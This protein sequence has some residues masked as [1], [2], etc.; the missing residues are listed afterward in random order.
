MYHLTKCQKT[1]NEY[2]N[3]ILE[4]LEKLEQDTPEHIPSF[5]A[6]GRMD[7]EE[8]ANEVQAGVMF[9]AWRCLYA[10]LMSVREEGTLPNLKGAYKRCIRMIISRLTAYGAKWKRWCKINAGTGKKKIIPERF[11]DRT[12]LKQQKHGNYEIHQ[13]L[14]KEAKKVDTPS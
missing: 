6:V 10:E 5:L 12:I 11:Q 13:E 14:I 8:V 2:W 9:I 7:E 4:L 3:K 1:R